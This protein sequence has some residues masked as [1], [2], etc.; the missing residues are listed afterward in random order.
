MVKFWL[1][2]NSTS[3]HTGQVEQA[4]NVAKFSSERGSG[5]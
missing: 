3:G 2:F 5:N 4:L 1:L